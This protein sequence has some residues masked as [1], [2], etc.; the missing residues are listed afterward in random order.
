MCASYEKK[1]WKKFFFASSPKKEVGSGV[2]KE[3]YLDPEPLVRDAD[4]DP[5][6]RGVDSDPRQSVTDPQ[7]C[8]WG[9]YWLMDWKEENISCVCR[10]L[11][12]LQVPVFL[13]KQNG[14]HPSFSGLFFL[15][16]KLSAIRE[17]W[18]VCLTPHSPQNIKK[19]LVS[20]LR[21]RI[22]MDPHWFKLLDPDPQLEKMLDPDPYPDPH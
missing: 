19:D 16:A 22:R 15:P 17:T 14:Q 11:V 5:V 7:H 3:L 21:I 8:L 2:G 13:H 12:Q 18:L 20:G 1:I 4:P 6:V 10:Y 9:K